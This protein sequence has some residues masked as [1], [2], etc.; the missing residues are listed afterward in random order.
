MKP[1]NRWNWE[2][3]GIVWTLLFLIG[4][5]LIWLFDPV[6][7]GPL[8]WLDLLNVLTRLLLIAPILW[9]GAAWRQLRGSVTHWGLRLIMVGI[10]AGSTATIC[11]IV[12]LPDELLLIGGCYTA[13]F[14]LVVLHVFIRQ[15]KAR[16]GVPWRAL[17]QLLGTFAI[18]AVLLCPTPYQVIYPGLTM[19]L[20]QYAEVEGYAQ[21]GELMS[22]LIFDRPAVPMDWVYNLLFDHYELEKRTQSL[23]SIPE[24]LAAVRA[25][26]L[27]A[28]QVAAAVALHK[29]GLG[30]GATYHGARVV[31]VQADGPAAG[32][33]QAG[34]II[35]G[36]AGESISRTE[37][38]IDWL[39]ETPPGTEIDLTL[40]RGSQII[41]LAVTTA[42][43]ATEHKR[44]VLGIQIASEIELDLPVDVSF[45]P[46]VLHE[47]GPSHGAM[48]TLAL[49][50]RLSANGVTNGH[51]VAGTGTIALDGSIG[52]IG[53]IKQ[54]AYT[55]GRTD[56]DVFF[57]P[58]S[59]LEEARLGSS[60]LRIVP[61]D[62]IDDILLW[63]R[64]HSS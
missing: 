59:Q 28:N 27:D 46:Y 9:G 31:F 35:T 37:E 63:L 6:R 50:D 19:N 43:H 42:A 36:V 15:L 62:H 34:D 4:V 64:T 1:G 57:V 39:G 33:L 38:L 54:K 20:G 8:Y 23:G 29:L 55:V 22:V 26:K 52:R 60:T 58:S 3:I 32:V 17:A 56:A 2:I 16:S 18:L 53:G 30:E 12:F 21:K 51:V 40:A 49:I 14:L 24:Q 48:L 5:E 47:G 44:S 41:Q 61:V 13:L 11:I 45:K 25:T 10:V 7:F